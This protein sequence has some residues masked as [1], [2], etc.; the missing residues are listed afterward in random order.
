M[1]ISVTERAAA[2]QSRSM[3]SVTA[4]G[5]S[6]RPD[7]ERLFTENYAFVWR[8]LVHFG[9]TPENADDAAQEVFLVVHRRLDNYDPSR[10]FKGWLYGIARRAASAQERGRRRA[11]TREGQGPS[12]IEGTSPENELEA[13][14]TA[15]W[16]Q[17]CL[18]AMPE[19]QREVFILADIEELTA[20]EISEALG[21]KLNTVYSRLRLAR[22]RFERDH[23]SYLERGGAE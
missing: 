17:A 16:V 9:L 1:E 10:S 22:E 18:D 13:R 6:S 11:A 4:P 12:T 7:F 21:V 5:P 23:Q 3:P 2:G 20:P 14:Q 19:E 8:S 15:A